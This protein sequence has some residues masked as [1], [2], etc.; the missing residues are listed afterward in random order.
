MELQL[1]KSLWVLIQ[2]TEHCDWFLSMTTP[3]LSS[4]R[5]IYFSCVQVLMHIFVEIFYVSS[6][7]SWFK[8]HEV[9][10]AAG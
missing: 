1:Q 5:L 2:D 9:C 8:T 4:H 3:T 7:G 10:A 6:N